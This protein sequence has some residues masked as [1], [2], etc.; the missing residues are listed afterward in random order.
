MQLKISKV[1]LGYT[2]Q[3]HYIGYV[4]PEQGATGTMHMDY[5]QMIKNVL[6]DLNG[7]AY[8]ID[9]NVPGN[10]V[11]GQNLE[12]QRYGY[13]YK[14]YDFQLLVPER[15]ESSWTGATAYYF[16]VELA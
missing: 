3:A 11:Y 14:T 10:I 16:Y 6:Y 5:V 1:D 8:T 2:Y 15:G 9:D 4:T 7:T 13:N 12:N